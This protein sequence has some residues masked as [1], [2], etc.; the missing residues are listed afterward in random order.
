M[1]KIKFRKSINKKISCKLMNKRTSRKSMYLPQTNEQKN[2]PQTNEQKNLPQTNSPLFAWLGRIGGVLAVL[3]AFVYTAGFIA[4]TSH[5]KVLGIHSAQ[6][7]AQQYLESGGLFIAVVFQA[8]IPGSQNLILQNSDPA[9]NISGMN[10]GQPWVSRWWTIGTCLLLWAVIYWLLSKKTRNQCFKIILELTAFLG[11]IL[12]IFFAGT[13][14]SLES[15]VL[16][17]HSCLQSFDAQAYGKVSA[18]F[19]IKPPKPD[20]PDFGNLQTQVQKS[21]G[22]LIIS[23]NQKHT[24]HFARLFA[25]EHEHGYEL[26]S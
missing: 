9:Y 4:L 5:Y 23:A 11:V 26:P 6:I 7:P 19:P 18:S 17:L 21:V 8:F 2:I 15:E 12:A 3:T 20:M 22:K 24:H 10:W 13:L 1:Y 16:R 25:L 14:I